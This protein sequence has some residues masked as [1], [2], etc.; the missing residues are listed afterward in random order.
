M[1]S[2]FSDWVPDILLLAMAIYMVYKT[3]KVIPRAVFDWI[4]DPLRM[5]AL[6]HK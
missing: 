5:K 2:L 1:S 3:P 6:F 4:L